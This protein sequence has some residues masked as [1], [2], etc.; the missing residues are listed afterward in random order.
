MNFAGTK[1]AV[2]GTVLL[3][4]TAATRAISATSENTSDI[5]P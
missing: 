1:N 5:N 3:Y 2:R 4:K